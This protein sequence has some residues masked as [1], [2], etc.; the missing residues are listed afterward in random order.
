LALPIGFSLGILL[1][2]L[3]ILFVSVRIFNMSYQPVYRTLFVSVASALM[4]GIAAYGT[5]YF[6]VEGINQEKFM[7][8]F[9]QGLV[10]GVVGIGTVILIHFLL[11]SKELSEVYSSFKARLF[12]T[13]VV[14]PQPEVI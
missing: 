4:G 2:L 8:I 14:A 12:K 10:A 11:N 6:V 3:L 7:G 1:E 13:D 5:L 9:V